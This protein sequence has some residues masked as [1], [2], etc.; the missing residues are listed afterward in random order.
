MILSWQWQ[1]ERTS[2][3]LKGMAN[4]FVSCWDVE[5]E[6]SILIIIHYQTSNERNLEDENAGF[7]PVIPGDLESGHMYQLSVA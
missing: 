4:N 2:E 1:I 7:C 6:I 5:I 3:R